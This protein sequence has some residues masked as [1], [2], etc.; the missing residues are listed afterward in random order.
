VHLLKHIMGG[1]PSEATDRVTRYRR[2]GLEIY[3]AQGVP[4]VLI[5]LDKA[6]MSYRGKRVL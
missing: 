6:L 5:V 1:I 4:T 3:V 2:S